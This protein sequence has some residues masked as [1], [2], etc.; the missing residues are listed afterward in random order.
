DSL[1]GHPHQRRIPRAGSTADGAVFSAGKF[2]DSVGTEVLR[3]AP[4]PAGRLRAR[5][6]ARR[7]GPWGDPHVM[8]RS[9]PWLLVL[10]LFGGFFAVAGYVLVR[11]AEV[12]REMPAYSIYAEDTD[13]L[14]E[15]AR[16]LRQ[17]G[18]E[19]VALTRPVQQLRPEPMPRL[20]VMIE[21]TAAGPMSHTAA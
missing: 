15:T 8:R 1:L 13:G 10:V 4:V 6:A 11:R 12:G 20:L 18:W 21:P 9:L 14:A 3:R 16:L 2:D 5:P 17:L 7:P 19:P